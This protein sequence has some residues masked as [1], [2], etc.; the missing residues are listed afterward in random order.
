MMA[1]HIKSPLRLSGDHVPTH[2]TMLLLLVICVVKRLWLPATMRHSL[3]SLDILLVERREVWK[4]KNLHIFHGGVG[5]LIAFIKL[6]DMIRK[7]KKKP[8][9]NR[10]IFRFMMSLPRN[11]VLLISFSSP[12]LQS[13]RYITC[14]NY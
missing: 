6:D 8:P 2:V 10:N 13:H 1:L 11:A 14:L 5:E 12:Q 9:K 7:K 3:H 4:I